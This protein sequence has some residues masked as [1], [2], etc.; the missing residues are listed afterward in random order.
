MTDPARTAAEAAERLELAFRR[1][2]DERMAGVP[3]VNPALAVEAVALRDWQGHWLGAL[4]TPWFIN[5][6]LLP[7]VGAW[8]AV[9]D[10]ESVWHSFP[11]GRFEFIGGSEPGIGPYH[12]CSLFSPVLEFADHETA[13]E[14][15][16][17]A[18]ESLFDP[19]LLGERPEGDAA[20]S[21]GMSRRDFLRGASATRS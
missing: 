21:R 18:V 13:R 11:S 3:I 19:E 9:A 4:V 10:R 15:A 14:T 16:R 8:R 5:L 12:A 17:V 7:G 1:I 20:D 2:R 6:V